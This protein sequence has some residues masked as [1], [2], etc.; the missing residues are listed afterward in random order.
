MT[1]EH[2]PDDGYWFTPKQHGYGAVPKTWQG[3]LVMMA[4]AAGLPI[5]SVPMLLLVPSDY[6]AAGFIVWAGFVAVAVWWFLKF[7]R[8]RTDGA[9]VWRYKGTPYRDM[10]EVKDETQGD[11][12]R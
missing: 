3:W 6:K 8:K 2:R 5:V 12:P 1:D 7:V 9:W 11:G 10:L 4:F